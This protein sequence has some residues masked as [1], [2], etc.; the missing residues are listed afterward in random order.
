MSEDLCGVPIGPTSIQLYDL[1]QE[2]EIK[3]FSV[4]A[5]KL[6]YIIFL[7]QILCIVAFICVL[8]YINSVPTLFQIN[9]EIIMIRKDLLRDLWYHIPLDL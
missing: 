5:I 2:A 7:Q 3:F 8:N 6:K 9:E 4:S 1:L